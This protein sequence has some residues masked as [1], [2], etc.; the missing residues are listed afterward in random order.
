LTV[1]LGKYIEEQAK[2]FDFSEQTLYRVQCLITHLGGVNLIDPS[3]GDSDSSGGAF[4][5][6]AIRDALEF[7]GL[8]P[9]RKKLPARELKLALHKF[10][11]LESQTEYLT[12]VLASL[13]DH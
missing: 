8:L 12:R 9:S 11:Q 5:M 7:A 1:I 3:C 6:F 4:M 2:N 13:E 10:N